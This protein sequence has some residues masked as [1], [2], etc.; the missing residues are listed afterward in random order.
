MCNA[1]VSGIVLGFTIIMNYIK[2]SLREKW[3]AFQ[4][5]LYLMWLS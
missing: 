5:G 1:F 4:V 3:V 2:M